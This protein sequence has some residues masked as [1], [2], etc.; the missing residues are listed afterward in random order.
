MNEWIIFLKFCGL[1]LSVSVICKVFI[2]VMSVGG[3]L[4]LG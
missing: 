2:L 4:S 1:N 3:L